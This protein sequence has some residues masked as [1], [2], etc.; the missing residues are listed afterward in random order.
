MC[1]GGISS[2]EER[3]RLEECGSSW[4]MKEEFEEIQFSAKRSSNLKQLDII[5]VLNYFRL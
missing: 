2:Q 5:N 3:G 1:E 4:M